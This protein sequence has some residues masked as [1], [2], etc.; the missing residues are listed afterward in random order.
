MQLPDAEVLV[1]SRVTRVAVLVVVVVLGVALD[2]GLH[3]VTEDLLP[4]PE[5]YAGSLLV[6]RFGFGPVAVAWAVLAFPGLALVFLAVE[7]HLTGSGTSKGVRYGIAVGLLVQVGMLEG[8]GMFGSDV[9]DEF[10]VGAADAIPIVLTGVLLGHLLASQ[11]PPRP[12]RPPVRQLVR[13]VGVFVVVFTAGRLSAAGTGLIDEGLVTR[14][15]A[16]VT[17]TL[18]MGAA[19]GCVFLLL[20]DQSNG[21]RTPGHAAVAVVGVFAVNWALFMLFVPMV[22]PDALA[23]VAVRVGLDIVLVTVAAAWT[24]S[25]RRCRRALAPTDHAALPQPTNDTRTALMCTP[26]NASRRPTASTSRSRRLDR[27]THRRCCSSTATVRTAG[28]SRRSSP[29]S[30][31]GTG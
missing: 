28:S 23:D 18:A 21:S 7:P 14:P 5:G 16:T 6:Q 15:F 3:M 2:I 29:T 10:V 24:G 25:S 9:G 20:P 8:V 31:T 1:V 22:F 19:I 12:P 30:A 11:G 17:W 27:W 26:R 13:C 4:L